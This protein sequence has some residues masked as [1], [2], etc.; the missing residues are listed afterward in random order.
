MT[1]GDLDRTVSAPATQE[2]VFRPVMAW[3]IT[4]LLVLFMIVN[5]ADKAVLGIVA[6]PI[7]AELGLS[8]AE[9]GFIGSA[10]FF[11]Y[12]ISGV[13]VGFLANRVKTKWV[14]LGLAVLWSVTQVPV[15]LSA[16]G[17]AL[18]ISRI[19]LGAAEGPATAMA[20]AGAFEWFPK[21]KRSLPSAWLS[22]G[23]SIA[24]IAVAPVLT[25]IVV[26]WGWRAAFVTLALVG[27]VWCLAWLLIG[28][29]GPY[30]TPRGAAAQRSGGG[31]VR[32]PFRSIALSR[33]FLGG[34]FGTFMVYGMVSVV[35]TWLP[36]YFEVGLGFSRVQAGAMFGLPSITGMIAMVGAGWLTDRM[37]SRGSSARVQRGLLPAISLLVGGGLLAVLPYVGGAWASVAVVVVAYGFMVVSLPVMNAVVSQI[38]PTRQQPGALG[39]FLALQTLSGLFAPALTGALVD[40]APTPGAGYAQAFQLFGLTVVVGGIVMALLVHPDRDAHKVLGDAAER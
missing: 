18:L 16:T 5:W 27:V 21:E 23:A 39:L 26:T 31:G 25:L 11:L 19:A 33:S 10:F 28:R 32:V 4:G 40:V 29:E 37:I 35:L 30:A 12:S 8:S 1:A 3:T 15:L 2:P 7:K 14:L 22:S 34:A 6:Q 38:S 13:A 20:N 36:S 24:K 17:A 9:I